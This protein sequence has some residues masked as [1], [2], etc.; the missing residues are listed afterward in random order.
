MIIMGQENL[1]NVMNVFFGSLIL[2]FSLT[3]FAQSNNQIA[4]ET[5]DNGSADNFNFLIDD[6][7]SV[8]AASK[9]EQKVT[10]APA[11]VSIITAKEIA[12]YGYTT[13]SD[14]LQ[15][16]RGFYVVNDRNYSYAGVR[17]FGQ[18]GDY[19][20]RLLLLIDGRR[21]ND[22]LYDSFGLNGDMGLDIDL[23]NRIEI[24]RG[25]GS[26][27]YGSSAFFGVINITTKSGRDYRGSEISLEI[28]S[29]S[30]R[31][32]R[33][34]AGSRFQNGLE[35]L[36]SASATKSDGEV[37]PYFSEFD[38]PASNDGIYE[39]H[40]GTDSR[41]LFAK[42]EYG[43][44]SMDAA[45]YQ[46]TKDIPTAS[47]GTVF[48]DPRTFTRDEKLQLGMSYQH[49]FDFGTQWSNHFSY[50]QFEHFGNYAYDYSDEG[51]G[52]YVVLNKDTASNDWWVLESQISHPISGS[53]RLISGM[54]YRNNSRQDQGN[55]D[56]E[57]YLDDHRDSEVFSLYVQDEI[58]VNETL[59]LNLG[60]RYDKYNSCGSHLSPRFAIILSPQAQ[61]AIKFLA[62]DAFRAPNIFELYYHDGYSTTKPALELKPEKIRSYEL[63]IEHYLPSNTLITASV[64][65]NLINDLISYIQDPNDLLFVYTNTDSIDAQGVELG[66]E[67]RF[68]KNIR[69]EFSYAYQVTKNNQTAEVLTN[70]PRHI[71]K[72]K[73]IAPLFS[74]R[75]HAGLELLYLSQR[76]TQQSI[77]ANAYLLTNL[78]LSSNRLIPGISLAASFY[79][80]FDV[81]VEHPGSTEHTQA[82]ISQ[83]GREFLL[84]ATYQF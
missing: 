24:V 66:L 35:I 27:L 48:N 73:L 37:R 4:F 41:N 77:D 79:N 36:V 13:L 56:E 54:E 53:Q 17:G 71:A 64:Y 40:D 78:T 69:S 16:V 6:I 76:K 75:L 44:F 65:S 28:G 80:L 63:V 15:S 32:G 23:I 45:Y 47:Y 74:E 11:S 46:V 30:T 19:N 67:T 72:A 39:N 57:I 9:H 14:I 22:T 8:F 2:F 29:Q 62:G 10:Q 49:T 25:P 58:N 84:R 5:N 43:G 61:T 68:G 3:T 1:I 50:G 31:I 42:L 83:N 7:P 82:V 20:T 33:A 52:S 38:D 59:T 60:L 21:M 55:F 34:T 70:S 26:S 51:D 81:K 18:P 12:L